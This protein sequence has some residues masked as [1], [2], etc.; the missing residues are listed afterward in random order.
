MRTL[1]LKSPE[2]SCQLFHSHCPCGSRGNSAPLLVRFS[3]D[4][5]TSNDNANARGR[6]SLNSG[7][8]LPFCHWSSRVLDLRDVVF[9]VALYLLNLHKRCNSFAL[10]FVVTTMKALSKINLFM[11]FP[12]IGTLCNRP[13]GLQSGRLKN[14]MIT[15]SSAWDTYHAA[16]LARLHGRRRGR[17]IGA[18]SSRYNNRYQ[19]LQVDFGG[20]AKVI[21][22]TTQGRQD[23]NQ[24]VTQYYVS[25]SLDRVHFSEYK[26]R[27]NRKVMYCNGKKVSNTTEAL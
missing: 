4:N 16:H 21:R 14:H 2:H 15:A 20:A 1:K 6:L 18:W 3:K 12:L 27:N 9:V 22:I 25:H 17:Y 8:Q 5:A 11:L 10:L 24:W 19:W 7:A 23:A 13:M 26:E